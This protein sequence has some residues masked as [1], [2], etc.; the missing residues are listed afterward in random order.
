MKAFSALRVRLREA[1]DRAGGGPQGEKHVV[2]CADSDAVVMALMLDPRTDVT[3]NLGA[4]YGLLHV[5]D[6]RQRWLQQPLRN[7]GLDLG[8]DHQITLGYTQVWDAMMICFD[9]LKLVH[10]WFCRARYRYPMP[11]GACLLRTAEQTLC[12]TLHCSPSCSMV[13]TTYQPKL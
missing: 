5:K 13:M 3:I 11:G 4:Q 1:E 12:R 9:T 7:A 2:L 6:L 10:M 8:K